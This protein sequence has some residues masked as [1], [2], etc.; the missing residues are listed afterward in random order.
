MRTQ[1]AVYCPIC[2]KDVTIKNERSGRC[3]FCENKISDLFEGKLRDF[4]LERWKV[5]LRPT[6]I[7]IRGQ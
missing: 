6:G 5:L 7:R 4:L 2:K 3:P 1:G